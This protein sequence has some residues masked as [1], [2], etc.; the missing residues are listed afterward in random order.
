LV[1]LRDRSR[2]EMTRM[3]TD[4]PT[5]VAIRVISTPVGVDEVAM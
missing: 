5:E 1:N 4:T 3:V 2:D